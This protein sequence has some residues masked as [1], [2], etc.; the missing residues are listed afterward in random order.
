MVAQQLGGTAADVPLSAGGASP[1]GLARLLRGNNAHETLS[2]WHF[3][4]QQAVCALT[5]IASLSLAE[6]SQEV[7][8]HADKEA[9]SVKATEGHLSEP[10]SATVPIFPGVLIPSIEVCSFCKGTLRLVGP[11]RTHLLTRRS[12]TFINV[13][14]KQCSN[15]DCLMIYVPLDFRDTCGLN[16]ANNIVYP[17]TEDVSVKY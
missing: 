14:H 16:C 6:L 9:A 13:F 2:P 15:R 11:K 4:D 10:A 12:L 1:A 5:P 17:L 7:L 3:I 8:L